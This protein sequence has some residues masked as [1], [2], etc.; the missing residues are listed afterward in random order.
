MMHVIKYHSRMRTSTRRYVIRKRHALAF[1]I[2]ELNKL[3]ARL[4]A[5]IAMARFGFL[6]VAL[7]VASI[8]M[9]TA[10]IDCS[11]NTDCN[12]CFNANSVGFH[13]YACSAVFNCD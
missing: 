6:V 2:V 5:E 13:Y 4:R 3:R 7:L 1:I 10:Q 12:T 11:Q 9:T 8:S